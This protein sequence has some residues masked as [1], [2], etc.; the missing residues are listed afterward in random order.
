MTTAEEPL[1]INFIPRS[2]TF[3]VSDCHIVTYGSFGYLQ[4]PGKFPGYFIFISIRSPIGQRTQH[5]R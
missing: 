5:L 4:V 3:T 2:L 1:I